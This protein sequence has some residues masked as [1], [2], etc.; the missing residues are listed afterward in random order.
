MYFFSIFKYCLTSN[1]LSGPLGSQIAVM[2]TSGTVIVEGN[3]TGTGSA[4]GTTIT[5]TV[6]I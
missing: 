5:M 6:N 1:M 4:Q 3:F 2:M